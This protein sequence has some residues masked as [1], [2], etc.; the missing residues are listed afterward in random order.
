M[1][2]EQKSSPPKPPSNI[3]SFFPESPE[4]KGPLL[5]YFVMLV[6]KNIYEYRK[7]VCMHICACISVCVSTYTRLREC[8]LMQ[9]LPCKKPVF[10]C[11]G[12]FLLHV[13]CSPDVV[14]RL[15]FEVASLVERWFEACGLQSGF[16]R[17]GTQAQQLWGMGLVVPQ[18]VGSFW[19]KD[20]TRVFCTG[21]WILYH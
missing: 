3:F 10:G 2:G 20:G 4:A 21:R 7:N 8:M 14:R 5:I 12:S 18:H 11:A 6:K 19:I 16:S 17:C 15:L 9:Q 13:G 1:W